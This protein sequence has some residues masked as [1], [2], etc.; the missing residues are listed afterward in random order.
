MCKMLLSIN[1]EHVINIL[2]GNKTYEYR[3]I[4]CK[5]KVDTI[6]IYATCPVQKIV[7]EVE[8]LEAIEMDKEKL[9]KITEKK[10]GITKEFYDKYYEGKDTA[11]AYKLGEVIKYDEPHSLSDIGIKMAP[12]SYM[13]ISENLILAN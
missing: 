7:G 3:K 2:Q 13:Y 8:V 1:P 11:V 12:Q 4:L 5:R 10:S 6:V 9:W